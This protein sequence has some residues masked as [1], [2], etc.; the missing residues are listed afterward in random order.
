MK[1]KF[2]ISILSFLVTIEVFAQDQPT[3]PFGTCG[4]VN[5]YDAAG[6]RTKRVYFCNNGI[7]P[8]PM[9]G[10][11]A[12]TMVTKEEKKETI[13]Y[14]SVDALYPNPTTGKFFVTL[15]KNMTNAS[16]SV[17]DNSG[18]TLTTFK[19]SGYKIDFDLSP[20]SSGMYYVRIEE[21][22]SVITKKVIKQ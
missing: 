9:R 20:Y 7:D 14:Q 13:E 17:I 8:Y 1:Y 6:N 22:G 11:P 4:I 10:A 2:I 15:S 18:K 3:L 5:V 16:V 19:A 21:E 12:D